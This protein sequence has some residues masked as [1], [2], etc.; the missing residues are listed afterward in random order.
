M[1]Y[2]AELYVGNKVGKGGFSVRVGWQVVATDEI[3]GKRRAVF[4]AKQ[5][6]SPC[7]K[8]NWLASHYKSGLNKHDLQTMQQ[9]KEWAE[10]LAEKW[11]KEQP[12]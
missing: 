11:N 3:T 5:R 1:K 12:F 10:T 7:C 4:D 8:S 6:K 2:T 9:Y